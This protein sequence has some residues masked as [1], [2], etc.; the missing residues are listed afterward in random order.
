MK[1]SIFSGSR[2]SREAV[3][4]QNVDSETNEF[5]LTDFWRRSAQKSS[6]E[7]EHHALSDAKALA[8]AFRARPTEFI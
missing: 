5:L 2:V 3:A 7:R 6:E 1:S 8:Y 4:I